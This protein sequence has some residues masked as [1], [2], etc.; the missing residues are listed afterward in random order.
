MYLSSDAEQI[1]YR[2]FVHFAKIQ[3]AIDAYKQNPRMSYHKYTW[4]MVKPYADMSYGGIKIYNFMS[5]Y[6]GGKDKTAEILELPRSQSD[7]FY[8]IYHREFPEIEQVLSKASGL[9][10]RRGYVKTLSGRRQRFPDSKFTHKAFNAVDQGSAAD[11]MKQKLYEL[12]KERK[13]TGFV[14]RMT[15]HDSVNGDAPDQ[16]CATMVDEILNRQSFDLRVPILWKTQTGQ[17][18]GEV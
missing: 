17:N 12:H 9:A 15:V 13:R 3:R 10:K 18:W 5:I 2:L 6:G 4:D 1:E 14:L 8:R 11:I 16:E 7:E